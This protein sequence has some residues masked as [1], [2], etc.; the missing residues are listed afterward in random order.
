MGEVV[1][2]SK[3]VQDIWSFPTRCPCHAQTCEI[4]GSSSVLLGIKSTRA[5]V[6]AALPASCFQEHWLRGSGFDSNLAPSGRGT[7]CELSCT[8]CPSA[9]W[10]CPA[11]TSEGSMLKRM[12]RRT[13]GSC[14]RSDISVCF[15][16]GERVEKEELPY[17]YKNILFKSRYSNLPALGSSNP[18]QIT[19]I[20]W[21]YNKGIKVSWN[22][23]KEF[24]PSESESA[25]LKATLISPSVFLMLQVQ[26]EGL[27]R[28]IHEDDSSQPSTELIKWSASCDARATALTQT[29]KIH[30]KLKTWLISSVRLHNFIYKNTL[31]SLLASTISNTDL[32]SLLSKPLQFRVCLIP[33]PLLPWRVILSTR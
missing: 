22:R 20:T 4:Q 18:S 29:I 16:P 28:P 24:I 1:T 10:G 25:F 26:T 30:F 11:L 31:L 19:W 21:N 9:G 5:Q 12:T 6:I 27:S 33:L 14:H 13:L 17:A 8:A 15:V 2:C 3:K 7:F 32:I 23:V